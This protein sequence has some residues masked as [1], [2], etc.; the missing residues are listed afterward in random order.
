MDTD[1]KNSNA[2]AARKLATTPGISQIIK[3]KG[4][5][6]RIVH[7]PTHVSQVEND[8]TWWLWW[9][10]PLSHSV[11][12]YWVLLN[13]KYMVEVFYNRMCIANIRSSKFHVIIHCNAGTC[14]YYHVGDLKTM[15]Y[16]FWKKLY[17]KHT[18]QPKFKN[19]F[20]VSYNNM[21]SNA[22]VVK[23]N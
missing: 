12:R 9:L 5:G 21:T 11:N 22:S 1:I 14:K 19:K 2:T 17:C 15:V 10:W 4:L 20:P 13:N 16:F 23:N 3:V 8:T 18:L 6:R 7:Y